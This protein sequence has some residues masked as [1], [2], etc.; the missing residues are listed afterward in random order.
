MRAEILAVGTEILLGDIVNTNAQYLS[1]R[2]ADLGI[3]VYHQTVVGDNEERLL[4]AYTQAFE[5]AD[6]VI[7][8]GGLGPTKDDLTKEIGAKYFNKELVLHNESLEYI[9]DYFKRLN[10][11]MS[12]GN[13]KQALIPG[14][15]TVLPNPNGTAPGCIIEGNNKVLIMLP[16][17]PKEM[18]PMFDNHAVRY[19]Q[20]FSDGILVSKILRVSG[21]GESA[22]A[23]KVQDIIDKQ[24]NPTVAP[25]AKDFEAILRITAKANTKEEA[26]KLIVPMEKEIRER[27][28]DN[29]YAEGETSLDFVVGEMLVKKNL[30]IST[31]ESCTGGLLAGTL[32]NYPGIST[33]FMEGAVTYSNE[34]K[35]K[36]LGVKG[37]TLKKYGAVSEETAREMAV[38]IARA[39]GTNVGISVTGIAGPGG[40]TEEKPVGLVYVGMYINGETK[41]RELNMSGDRQKVR[42]RT[43]VNIL[44]WL[45]RELL[46]R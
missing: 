5:R 27:L 40:G 8:T 18:I 24:T 26:E 34:A 16:G 38:G 33:V 7:A 46:N 19:L 45:R 32:I 15:A 35:M 2:L 31:A 37:E 14:G 23:E 17:P 39:A 1:K 13:R 28:G 22:M 44:D 36:R 42:N 29:I 10:R 20:K 12:E 3:S 11:T 6:I 25:Y 30:T 43:V 4:K 41:V 21:L 9:E